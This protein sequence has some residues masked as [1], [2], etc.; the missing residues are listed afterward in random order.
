VTAV[1]VPFRG[2]DAKRRLEPLSE[3]FRTQLA[4]AMLG[5][6]LQAA[7]AVGPVFVVSPRVPGELGECEHVPDLGRGLGAAVRA[8]LDAAAAAAAAPPYLVV[9]ADL[10]CARPRDLLALAGAIPAGGLALVPARDGTTNALGLAD[11]RV[12]NPV[13][14][15]GSAR[16]FAG[17]APSR[18][19]EAPNLVDDVDTPD[20]LFRLG[21]RLGRR[22]KRVLAALRTEEAA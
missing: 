3:P 6:V 17:L 5:D 20:D 13:Y 22:T 19:V 15:A 12:F 2:G 11:E 8:G 18:A 14:G 9:N 7:C 10:P 21:A 4:E 16:R 1:I